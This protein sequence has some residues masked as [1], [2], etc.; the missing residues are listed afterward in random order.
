MTSISPRRPVMPKAFS[1]ASQFLSAA[2]LTA[3][4]TAG[5]QSGPPPGDGTQAG[6]RPGDP[7]PA[8]GDAVPGSPAA[9]PSDPEAAALQSAPL[10]AADEPLA[11]L[12]FIPK[13]DVRSF[14]QAAVMFNQPMVALG[15]FDE[16]DQNLLAVDPPLPGKVA[17][18]NQFTL[19]FVPEKPVLGSLSFTV[20]LSPDVKSLSG[21]GLPPGSYESSFTLPALGVEWFNTN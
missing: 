1:G 21:A 19:A 12:Q 14:T 10:P 2:L 18:I 5:C 4:L 13:G 9:P 7:A 17:W 6:S 16:A 20:K 8:A 3:L 11:V 15:A